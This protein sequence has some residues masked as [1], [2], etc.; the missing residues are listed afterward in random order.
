MK[1]ALVCIAKNEDL[2][3]D[4]WIDYHFK[5]GFDEIFVYQN[6]WRFNKDIENALKILPPGAPFQY[7]LTTID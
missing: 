7:I 4:E 3:I 6:N 2:Y 1:V 5:L